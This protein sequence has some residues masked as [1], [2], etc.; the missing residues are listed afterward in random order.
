[1]ADT[2]FVFACFALIDIICL[3]GMAS[4]FKSLP[5]RH[6]NLSWKNIE[7]ELKLGRYIVPN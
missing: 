1:M 5:S 4:Y 3:T 2:V 6:M 7:I